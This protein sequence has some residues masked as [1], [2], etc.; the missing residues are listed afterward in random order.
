M[1]LSADKEGAQLCDCH[2]GGMCVGLP[3]NPNTLGCRGV[4]RVRLPAESEPMRRVAFL[5]GLS[6]ALLVVA[7][8]ADCNAGMPAPLPTDWTANAPRPSW[9][10]SRGGQDAGDAHWQ[11]LSFFVACFLISAWGFKV[12][13][14][15]LR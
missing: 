1:A 13:W 3:T 9:V 15:S 11:A 5:C 2:T 12:V 14:N 7:R 10:G 4:G 8:V 6:A